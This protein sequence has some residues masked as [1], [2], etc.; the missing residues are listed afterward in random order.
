MESP[1]TPK[2][3]ER[4]SKRRR[5]NK[6]EENE[7]EENEEDNTLPPGTVQLFNTPKHNVDGDENNNNNTPK[8]IKLKLTV[9][10]QPIRHVI[11]NNLCLSRYLFPQSFIHI[12]SDKN[13][14]NTRIYTY[15]CAIKIFKSAK[16]RGF[17][18]LLTQTNIK[19]HPVLIELLKKLKII[20]DVNYINY[21]N[22]LRKAYNSLKDNEVLKINF[23]TDIDI[24]GECDVLKRV[25]F[26]KNLIPFETQIYNG[27][28]NEY[29]FTYQDEKDIGVLKKTGG[30]RKKTMKSKHSKKH[31]NKHSKTQH[32]K[33]IKK[34]TKKH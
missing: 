12:I 20:D 26:I 33:R 32:H 1:K 19:F 6:A 3:P 8:I 10:D 30:K 4:S 31:N 13:K 17:E 24:I 18:N 34:H 9:I 11:I 16:I 29:E 23:N 7:A 25:H 5:P 14:P 2:T 28:I 21:I 15:E 27:D 22:Q